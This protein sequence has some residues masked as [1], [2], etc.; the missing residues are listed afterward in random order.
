MKFGDYVV[1]GKTTTDFY[2]RVLTE[3]SNAAINSIISLL[4]AGLAPCEPETDDDN[5]ELQQ[6]ATWAGQMADSSLWDVVGS[7]HLSQDEKRQAVPSVRR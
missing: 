1:K 3:S 2:A 4:Y 7:D 6:A 5:E